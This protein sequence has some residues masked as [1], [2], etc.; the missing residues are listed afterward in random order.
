MIVNIRPTV[1]LAGILAALVPQ[2][3]S[4][5][6]LWAPGSADSLP[7]REKHCTIVG[8]ISSK[9]S[10]CNARGVCRRGRFNSWV[11]KIPGRRKW[12]STPVF[13]PGESHRWRTLAGY[14][15]RDCRVRHCWATKQL[16]RT[17]EHKFAELV[18]KLIGGL[19]WCWVVKDPPDIARDTGSIPNPGRSHMPQGD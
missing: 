6:G 2:A 16:Q 17:V 3:W 14:L 8:Q 12:Q 10:A 11:G 7:S 13:L 18:W 5:R 19:S 4:R 9:E 1:I 15:P